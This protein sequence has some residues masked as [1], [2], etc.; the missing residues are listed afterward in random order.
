MDT[1]TFLEEAAPCLKPLQVKKRE[2]L[3]MTD[4]HTKVLVVDDHQVSREL[5]CKVLTAAGYA[6]RAASDGL[7]AIHH[8]EQVQCDVVLTDLS[9]P[10]LDGLDLLTKIRDRWPE[11]RVV[12]HSDLLTWR[13]ARLARVEGAYA[14]L[15]KSNITAQ[16]LKTIA[17]ASAVT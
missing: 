11:S 6:V 9:M 3:S 16:L 5:V 1:T 2:Y 10:Q 8:M 4:Q 12:V 13:A 14:C 15:C 7:N 17:A